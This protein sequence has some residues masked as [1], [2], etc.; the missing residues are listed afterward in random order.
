[1]NLPVF[2]CLFVHLVFLVSVFSPI[3]PPPPPFFLMCLF[4]LLFFCLFFCFLF[5]CFDIY[6]L[7]S[8][9]GRSVGDLVGRSVGWLDG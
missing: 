4:L 7:T 6:I 1:M 8:I 2:V 5:F 3:S 9:R